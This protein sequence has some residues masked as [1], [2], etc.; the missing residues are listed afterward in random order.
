MVHALIFVLF[1][2]RELVLSYVHHRSGVSSRDVRCGCGGEGMGG[3]VTVA[4][5]ISQGFLFRV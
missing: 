3:D 5:T 2:L 4:A 1:Q